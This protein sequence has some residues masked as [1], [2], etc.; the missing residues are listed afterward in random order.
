MGQLIRFSESVS[1]AIHALMH[2]AATGEGRLANL[3]GIATAYPMSKAHLSKIM[4][5]LGK[6]GLVRAVRGPRGGYALSDSPEKVTLLQ[7]YEAIEGKVA[8]SACMLGRPVCAAGACQ[9]GN[10]VG[11]LQVRLGNYLA[12]TS[13]GILIAGPA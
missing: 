4:Q 13:L 10:F 1:L 12:E 3:E 2:L 9:L 6:A 7:I 8:S 5:R 11:D